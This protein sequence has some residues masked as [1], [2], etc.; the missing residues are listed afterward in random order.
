MTYTYRI[1]AK[2]ETEEL[3][4]QTNEAERAIEFMFNVGKQGAVVTVTSGITGEILATVNDDEPYVTEEWALMSLGW[5]MKT[6][7]E[8]KAEI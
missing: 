7:W 5:L 3:D 8:T 6:A 2:F 4:F 1:N